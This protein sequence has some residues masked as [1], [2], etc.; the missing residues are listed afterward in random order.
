MQALNRCIFFR[1]YMTMKGRKVDGVV[2]RRRHARFLDRAALL[3]QAHRQGLMLG[4]VN[5]SGTFYS[6]SRVIFAYH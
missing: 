4:V 6:P 1:V 3:T 5:Y 2:P